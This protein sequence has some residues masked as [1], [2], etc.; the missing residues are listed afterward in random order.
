[1]IPEDNKVLIFEYLDSFLWER[2]SMC[3]SGECIHIHVT[4]LKKETDG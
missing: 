1:M 4:L 3:D 2:V